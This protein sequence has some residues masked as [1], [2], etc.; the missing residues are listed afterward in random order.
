MC[1]SPGEH[2]I[3]FGTGIEQILFQKS[4]SQVHGHHP[5]VGFA[6]YDLHYSHKRY[7][8]PYVV[9]EHSGKIE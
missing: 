7:L 8:G 2:F 9:N 1:N 6:E 4:L 5:E 3:L